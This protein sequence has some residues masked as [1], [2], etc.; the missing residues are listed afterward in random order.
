MAK[1]PE[2]FAELTLIWMQKYKFYTTSTKFLQK[3][4]Y[5]NML[6]RHNIHSLRTFILK[7]NY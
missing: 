5:Y 3:I 1:F 2:N 7:N 4:L 6:L